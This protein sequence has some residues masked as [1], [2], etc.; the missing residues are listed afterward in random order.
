MEKYPGAELQVYAVWFDVLSDDER[1][2]WDADLMPDPRVT[3]FWDENI[4]VGTWLPQQKEYRDLISGPLAWDIFFLYGPE[5]DWTDAPLPV[6]GSGS[7]IMGK[8]ESLRE[9]L[10]PMLSRD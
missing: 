3:H 9:Q 8:K 5:A 7:T 6:L 10:A 2:A 1:S 4:D